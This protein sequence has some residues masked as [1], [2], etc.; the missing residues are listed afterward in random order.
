MLPDLSSLGAYLPVHRN[1]RRLP[2][3]KPSAVLSTLVLPTAFFVLAYSAPAQAQS[4]K[5]IDA[6]TPGTWYEVPNSRMNRVAYGNGPGDDK[7][8]AAA[9]HAVE[10]P[11]AI[12]ND[13]SGA[14]FDTKRDNLFVWGGGHS[15]YAGNEVYLFNMDSLSW[16]RL[17]KPSQP[18]IGVAGVRF[19][20]GQPDSCHTYNGLVYMPD[21]D[22]V[23]GGWS[24]CYPI[25]AGGSARWLFNFSTNSWSLI[26][27]SSDPD[28]GAMG[29][30]GIN[31][32]YDPVT[33]HVWIEQSGHL[34]EFDPRTDTYNYYS[35]G[36]TPLLTSRGYNIYTTAAIDPADRLMVATGAGGT[37]L[38]RLDRP[39]GWVRKATTGDD[40]PSSVGAPGFVWDPR[41]SMFVAWV[42][43]TTM[44]TLDPRSWKW[45]SYTPAAGNTVTPMATNSN[46]TYGRFQYVPAHD[47]FVVVNATN[48]DVYVYKPDFGPSSSS[49][50]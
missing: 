34:N 46:G 43:G 35:D 17:T 9:V 15:G 10:G 7:K 1:V 19:A 16:S 11:Q 41:T 42:G 2:M 26:S 14:A 5:P 18:I 30:I 36:A 48:Q 12:M 13:W 24:A 8:L 45:T 23:Y 21:V 49:P 6:I 50:R 32:A 33:G 38:W 22:K 20:D 29:A 4:I 37:Y 40:S 25:G 44:Y 47:V 27:A 3:W 39:G 28:Q 31:T